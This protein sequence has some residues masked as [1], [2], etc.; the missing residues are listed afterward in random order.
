[1]QPVLM[2]G[3]NIKQQCSFSGAT[4]FND[5]KE[6]KTAVLVFGC[7]LFQGANVT[8]KYKVN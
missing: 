2:T 5:W 1:V 6:Y 8:M 4:C 3:R 7:N